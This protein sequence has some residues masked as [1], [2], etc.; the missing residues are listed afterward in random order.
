[1]KKTIAFIFLIACVSINN[2]VAA[3]QKPELTVAKIMQDPKN[4]VGTS[5]QHVYWSEDGKSVYF[6]WN[7]EANPEDSLYRA[8]APWS[9]PKKVSQTEQRKLPSSKGEYNKAHTQKVYEKNG[10]IYLYTISTGTAKRLTFTTAREHSPQFASHDKNV[11]Y[12]VDNNLFMHELNTGALRQL[13]DFRLGSEREENKLNNQDQWLKNDQMELIQVLKEDE[14]EKEQQKAFNA[15]YEE[16]G[17]LKIYTGTKQINN[18]SLSPD[19]RYITYS[20]FVRVKAKNTIVP[21]YVTVSGYTEDQNA[22]PKVGRDPYEMEVGIYDINSHKSYPV[23]TENLKGLKTPPAFYAEYDHEL[24]TPR[25]VFTHKPLWSEDGKY[26]II[27]FRAKDNK[28]RWIGLLD[29]T[30]GKVK[31]LDHQHDEAWIAGPG[32]GW[33]F[34]SG[35]MGW[36]PD[37][38][39]IFFQSEESGYSHLY[40]INVETGKKD[41]LT[42]GKFEIYNPRISPD[43]KWWYFEANPEHPG[44]RKVYK[45]PLKG[46]KMTTVVDL[47]G[48]SEAWFSPDY[49]KV[50]IINSVANRPGE[51]FILNTEKSNNLVQ[52]TQSQTEEW[53]QYPW[54]MPEFITFKARDNAEVHARLYQP[55]KSVK[56][57]AAIIFVHGAGYLQNAHQWWS[58]YFREYMFHNLLADKGYT[59]LD[60]DY[61]GSAGY[62]R[63]WRT[64]IYRHMGGFD[65]TD[66]A[67]G[68]RHLA[69]HYE[70]DAE[71]IGIYGGSYGGFI[72][73]MALF[74]EGDTFTA[75]AAL[76]SVTD[77]AHYNHG[78]TSN[79]LNTPV[80]DSLAYR[81]SS[82]IYYAEGLKGHLL[83]CHGMVDTNV[84]FQ[85]VVRL[86]QRLIEL[87]K[88]NWEL[89]VYPKEGHGFVHPESWTDEYSRILK[90]FENHLK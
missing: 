67:D 42:K 86:S 63:D 43:E 77:W 27:S 68:A 50:A 40:T 25:K 10:D 37:N 5:P 30:S 29:A 78:Y 52:V 26:A 9:S 84:H 41:A 44:V 73:L 46:G 22:R 54:R 39:H 53:K 13:T 58:S 74:T 82:P 80:M 8:S 19:G 24:N 49:S 59:I 48:K 57:G 6:Q 87:G 18:I 69:E 20:L 65:L 61:R 72:T 51:L 45:M 60:I 28:D 7:P 2:Q 33:S 62:G 56:N 4:W 23:I 89:A 31:E 15:G 32:I 21:D 64:G 47:P 70:I 76:R 16:K 12:I 90:L 75:G 35:E 71:R 55:E 1:M 11:T 17:P 88:D 38:K 36:L 34:S 79:I 66:Q 83:I 81:K 85:D 3:Q 14:L